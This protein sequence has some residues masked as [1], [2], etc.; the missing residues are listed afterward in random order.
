MARQSDNGTMQAELLPLFPL[1]V[2]LLPHNELPLH[3]FEERYKE[4]IRASLDSKTGFGVVL[5]SASGIAGAGC[6]AHIEQVLKEYP[7][8]RLDILT[9]GRLRFTISGLDEEK[10][11]LRATVDYFGDDD[12]T[13]P[14]ELRQKALEVCSQIP[15]PEMLSGQRHLS[16]EDDGLSFLLAQRIADAQ[17]RQQLLVSRSETGRLQKLI[18]YAPGYASSRRQAEHVKQVAGQN[19]H[20][21]KPPS[22]P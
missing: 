2:V 3:I 15:E 17:L 4:M 13:A 7:D 19:G 10:A 6:T 20:G 8:G 21:R 1:S 16:S 5:A 14:L 9:F 22:L 12:F 11:Y 18:E